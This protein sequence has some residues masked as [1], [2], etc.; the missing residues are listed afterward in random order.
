VIFAGPPATRLQAAAAG[1]THQLTANY[2][3][4]FAGLTVA[5]GSTVVQAGPA[6]N[7]TVTGP[8]VN[9]GELA[10]GQ[11]VGEPGL[12]DFGLTGAQVRVESVGTLS[13]LEVSRVDTDPP[14]AT[15]GVRTGRYWTI[16]PNEGA[17]DYSADLTLPQAVT[18]RLT[19]QN[20]RMQ[21]CNREKPVKPVNHR[22]W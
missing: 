22:G 15:A 10:K 9:D 20:T 8:L 6:S 2:P 16:V 13:S 7:V 4:V 17:G 21:K 5:G 19:V 14:G 18:S 3:T 11:A 12:Y 1:V